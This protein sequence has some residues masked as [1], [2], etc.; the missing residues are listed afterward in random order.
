MTD[1]FFCLTVCLEKDIREDDAESL[2]NAIE[3]FSGV[4]KVVGHIAN[5]DTWMAEE[6]A[7]RELGQKI[8]EVIY[9]KKP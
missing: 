4:I 8:L 1:R 7:R 9:N 5:P 3:Q 2:I 6:R